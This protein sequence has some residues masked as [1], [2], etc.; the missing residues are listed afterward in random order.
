MCSHKDSLGW[1]I[2]FVSFLADAA[3]L[4]GRALFVVIIVFWN[5]E[6]G[7]TRTELSGVMSLAHLMQGILTPISGYCADIYPPD[8]I[9]GIGLTFLTISIALVAT[10]N[11]LWS[12]WL[13]YG[14]LCGA[15]F[16]ILN[17]N[18]YAVAVTK[19]VSQKHQGFAVGLAS[20]GSTFGQFLLIPIFS[21]IINWRVGYICLASAVAALILPSIYLLRLSRKRKEAEA[22][23]N[24]KTEAEAILTDDIQDTD[25][26]DATHS[27]ELTTT[28]STPTQPTKSHL[29]KLL[30]SYPYIALT[31]SFFICGITTSGFIETHMVSIVVHRGFTLETGAAAFAVLCGVNGFSMIISGWLVDR[32]SRTILL[33]LIFFGRAIAYLIL[34]LAIQN[35]A[36]LF[37][38]SVLFGF[39]DYSVVPPVISLVTSHAGKESVGLGVG[40][41]LAFHSVGASLGSIL[42]GSLFDENGNYQS[43]LIICSSLCIVASAACLSIPREPLFRMQDKKDT[44]DDDDDVKKRATKE[45]ELIG[46]EDEETKN[47]DE[48]IT[49]DL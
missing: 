43:A 20:S 27:P 32:Y 12:A 18:V 7:W 31:I 26:T 8:F 47:I 19:A 15:A 48:G 9:V 28:P 10:V 29:K 35:E 11:H 4:G 44:M 22:E 24:A 33:A 6:F 17:L 39:C 16:G 49:I 46:R 45:V 41:L 2:V 13:I 30:F 14:G 1:W 5:K 38:F 3:S 21:L 23:A 36:W 40:I 37:T 34:I 42:G 25:T